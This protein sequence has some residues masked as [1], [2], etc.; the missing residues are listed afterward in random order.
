[1][2]PDPSRED[3]A[4]RVLQALY[5]VQVV[6]IEHRVDG[7][8]ERVEL[9]EVDEPAGFRVHRTAYGQLHF[10]RMSVETRALMPLRNLRQVMR[11][12]ELELVDQTDVHG[13]RRGHSLHE[14][15][16]SA[17]KSAFQCTSCSPR[18]RARRTAP[19][20]SASAR[21]LRPR[22]RLVAAACTRS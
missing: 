20:P 18:N 13:I 8:P 22:T 1:L 14:P 19:R 3:L 21:S 2:V 11:G 4:R 7:L 9:P 15:F 10:E 5:L 12:F 17:S 6:V 16:E